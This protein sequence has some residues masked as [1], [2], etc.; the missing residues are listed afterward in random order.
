M[1]ET[2][3]PPGEFLDV[4]AL[5]PPCY[6]GDLLCEVSRAYGWREISA[7]PAML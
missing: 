7:L 6:V 3:D 4:A 1:N 2:S 5:E